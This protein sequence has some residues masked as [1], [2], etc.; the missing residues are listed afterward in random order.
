MSI[1]E[2]FLR[3][4]A[5]I[6]EYIG[7]DIMHTI[8]LTVHSLRSTV[9]LYILVTYALISVAIT[10][11]QIIKKRIINK[12]EILPCVMLVLMAIMNIIIYIES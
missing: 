2:L 5:I 6:N 7:V 1:V 8:L 9:L 11:V 4:I 12:I 10:V 3:D